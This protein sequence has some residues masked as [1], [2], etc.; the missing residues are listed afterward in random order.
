MNLSSGECLLLLQ[1]AIEK[2]Q[3]TAAFYETQS[4]MP[5]WKMV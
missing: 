2:E 1:P 3:A 5:G 4:K